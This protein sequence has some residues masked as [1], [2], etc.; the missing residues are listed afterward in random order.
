[1][2]VTAPTFS[3]WDV[4]ADLTPRG[5]M[6]VARRHSCVDHRAGSRRRRLRPELVPSVEVVKMLPTVGDPAVLELEDDA[7]D[8]IQ[9]LAIPLPRAALDAD[10]AVLVI[11]KQV[12]Q[13]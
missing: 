5:S 6:A 9:V 2:S 12:L 7:V 3:L 4:P 10:H 1:M 8:N 13:L 11:C